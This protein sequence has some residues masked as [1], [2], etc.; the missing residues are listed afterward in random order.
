MTLLKQLMKEHKDLFSIIE[1]LQNVSNDRMDLSNLTNRESLKEK[2]SG[3]IEFL[4]AHGELEALQLYP[5]LKESLPAN[6]NWM[7]G[8]TEIQEGLILKET[9]QLRDLLDEPGEHLTREKLKNT[10]SQLERWVVEHI[11]MEEKQ[12]FSWYKDNR[13]KP[14]GEI[15]KVPSKD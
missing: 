15:R 1:E 3:L 8:M 7:L 2:L 12:L 5:V 6:M 10:V 13:E 4:K 11:E 14:R 9:R